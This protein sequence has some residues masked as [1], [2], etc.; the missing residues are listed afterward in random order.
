[1][2]VQMIVVGLLDFEK[3]SPDFISQKVNE[4]I[5]AVVA[6]YPVI[7]WKPDFDRNEHIAECISEAMNIPRVIEFFKNKSDEQ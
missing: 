1:M 4:H 5:D 6:R 2:D 7:F 3:V